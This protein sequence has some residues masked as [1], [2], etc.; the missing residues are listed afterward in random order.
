MTPPSFSEGFVGLGGAED[1]EEGAE[2]SEV[3]TL[4]GEALGEGAAPGSCSFKGDR[5]GR[6]GGMI[7]DIETS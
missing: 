7:A 4:R 3:E 6:F 1:E 5:G 2:R